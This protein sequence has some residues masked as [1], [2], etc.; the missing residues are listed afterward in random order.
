MANTQPLISESRPLP[1]KLQV[2][3]ILVALIMV[4]VLAGLPEPDR[5]AGDGSELLRHG[6][7]KRRALQAE[8]AARTEPQPDDAGR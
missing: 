5:T 2:L 8:A 1:I 4:V 7:A 3:F 6:W